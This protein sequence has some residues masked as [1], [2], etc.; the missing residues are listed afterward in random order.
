MNTTEYN[1]IFDFTP[2][3]GDIFNKTF[4]PDTMLLKSL[5]I[6]YNGDV[7]NSVPTICIDMVKRDVLKTNDIFK[8]FD[9]LLVDW[10]DI[11]ATISSIIFECNSIAV[12]N[13]R[14]P[15]NIIIMSNKTGKSFS[16]KDL[17]ELV[18]ENTNIG[19]AIVD[20]LPNGVMYVGYEP[21][22]PPSGLADRSVYSSNTDI[23]YTVDGIKTN[24]RK[25]NV[26]K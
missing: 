23:Y 22:K 15:A 12:S 13:R 26:V 25:F 14:G 21:T 19:V 24:W 4:D 2:T 11:D 5:H 6:K 9:E 17:H 20:E 16:K 1:Y 18:D 7:D 10:K 3:K 8:V